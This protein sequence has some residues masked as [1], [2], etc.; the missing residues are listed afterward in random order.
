MH[1]PDWSWRNATENAWPWNPADAVFFTVGSFLG[2]GFGDCVPTSTVGR[3]YAIVIHFAS[4][5]AAGFCVG[6]ALSDMVK[7][8]VR[9][10]SDMVKSP[11][12]PH[13]YSLLLVVIFN[14]HRRIIFIETVSTIDFKMRYLVTSWVMTHSPP[15]PPAPPVN[16]KWNLQVLARRV[17][18][19]G[20]WQGRGLE[21]T[22]RRSH[23]AALHQWQR[24]AKG[25]GLQVVR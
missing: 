12:P 17:F 9:V 23:T 22:L 8:Q 13:P 20:A 16:R 15:P 5:V 25:L 11:P 18:V 3:I 10:F 7:G 2:N 14:S 4:V 6:A 24:D 21:R 19:A 1:G